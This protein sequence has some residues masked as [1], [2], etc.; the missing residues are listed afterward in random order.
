MQAHVWRNIRV[1]LVLLM[2]LLSGRQQQI[3]LKSCLLQLVAIA[4]YIFGK[5]LYQVGYENCYWGFINHIS[6]SRNANI[7]KVLAIFKN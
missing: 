1:M 3:L 5:L 4:L 7:S 6:A 2:V